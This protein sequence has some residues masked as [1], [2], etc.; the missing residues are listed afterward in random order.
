MR[1]TGKD[2]DQFVASTVRGFP[3]QQLLPL[4]RRQPCAA[5]LAILHRRI[6]FFNRGSLTRRTHRGRRLLSLLDGTVPIPGAEADEHSFWVFP[7]L[8]DEPTALI[9]RLLSAGFDASLAHSMFVVP[10]P[11]DRPELS[12][13][14]CGRNAAAYCAFAVLP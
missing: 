10:P 12:R 1:L 6:A 2:P 4:I 14:M 5:L 3:G 13:A 7:M 8:H 9:R 11:Q